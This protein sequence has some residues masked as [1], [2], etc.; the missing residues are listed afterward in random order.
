MG[1]GSAMP[2]T[3]PDSTAQEVT[4]DDYELQNRTA[5]TI[6]AIKDLEEAH[7]EDAIATMSPRPGSAQLEN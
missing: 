4:E 6:T 1:S 7:D 2:P 5:K 3:V